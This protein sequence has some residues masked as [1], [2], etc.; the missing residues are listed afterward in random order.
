[1]SWCKSENVLVC[2]GGQDWKPGE[3][4]RRSDGRWL[5]R[6]PSLLPLSTRALESAFIKPQEWGMP[7]SVA[8]D[9]KA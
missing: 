4:L 3:A 6:E 5:L 1:M 9:P 8:R 7:P 2:N